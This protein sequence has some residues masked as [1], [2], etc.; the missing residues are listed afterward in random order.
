VTPADKPADIVSALMTGS[1]NVGHSAV[2]EWNGR[3][4]TIALRSVPGTADSRMLVSRRALLVTDL[5]SG[6]PTDVMEV[7]WSD[8]LV[9]AQHHWLDPVVEFVDDLA[10]DLVTHLRTDLRADP[11][12]DLTRDR[13]TGPASETELIVSE[14]FWVEPFPL[15]ARRWPDASPGPSLDVCEFRQV[16][17]VRLEGNNDRSEAA[18][19]RLEPWW[20]TMQ[21]GRRPGR[22]VMHLR[23][24]LRKQ[25]GEVDAS[26]REWV[27]AVH[28]EFAHPPLG[29]D[30]LQ[31]P[32]NHLWD[33][34]H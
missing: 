2:W 5:D 34:L 21:C 27:E 14:R 13:V 31:R 26:L 19:T 6:E 17:R 9:P 25:W 4:E 10:L 1:T 18:V 23:G 33:T 28:P 12:T 7:P 8:R 15:S 3:T 30:T 11:R 24:V 22:M 16:R 20:P 32:V 29:A